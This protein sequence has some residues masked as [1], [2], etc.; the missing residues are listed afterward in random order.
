M[1]KYILSLTL[2]I[3]MYACNYEDRSSKSMHD[4]VVDVVDAKDD[5]NISLFVDLSNRISP[6]DHPNSS[7]EYYN[8]D[9]GYIKS[10]ANAFETHI[11]NKKLVLLNDRMQLFL[12]PIP[13]STE[14]NDIIAELRYS[15]NRNNTT[16]EKVMLVD[17]TY[18]TSCR[19]IYQQTIEDDN[20]IGSDIWGFFNNQIDDYCLKKGYRNILVIL[21][22][23]YVYHK[24]N[25]FSKGN[26]SSFLIPKQISRLKLNKANW[27]EELDSGDYGFICARKDLKD[28]DIEVMV[29]GVN[30]YGN[31]IQENIIREYWAKWLREMGVTKYSIKA[32]DL[33]AML[34]EHIQDFILNK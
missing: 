30:S 7:L 18:V 15:F 22:D 28:Y 4:Q 34:D 23:G 17:S 9:L 19:K 21:T 32:A 20:Y 6:K 24:D 8:R 31:K 1:R 5:L 26:R 3:F 27:K 2:L 14:I 25:A 16:K 33:P 13:N 29:I 12:D 10:C 11:L